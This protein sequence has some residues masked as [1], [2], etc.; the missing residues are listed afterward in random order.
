M[1]AHKLGMKYPNYV[2]LTYGSY[3]SQWWINYEENCSPDD[4]AKVLQF[5]LAALHFDVSCR[6]KMF[7]HFC[8]DATWVLAHTLHGSI[9]TNE[10]LW[11]ASSSRSECSEVITDCFCKLQ[12]NLS[13]QMMDRLQTLKFKGTSVS[14]I[15]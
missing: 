13:C 4:I 3:K 5:S 12:G 15:I 10:S 6:D 2:F 11:R 8:Y 7:Y 14:I 9:G 1:Q